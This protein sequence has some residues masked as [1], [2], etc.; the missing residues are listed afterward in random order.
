MKGLSVQKFWNVRPKL[1]FRFKAEFMTGLGNDGILGISVTRINLPKIEGQS[2]EGSIYFGN[3]NFVIPVWNI[4]SRKLEITFEETDNLDISKF[5]DKLNGI[6]WSSIPY[7]MTIVIHE[8]EEHMRDDN[9]QS[10]G[11]VCHLSSYDELSFKRDGQAGQLTIIATFIIDTII[12]NWDANSKAIYGQ[13]VVAA[14]D[15]YNPNL[16]SYKILSKNQEFKYGDLNLPSSSTKTPKKDKK[17]YSGDKYKDLN[18]DKL[19]T[20]AAFEKIKDKYPDCAITREQLEKVQKENARRMSEAYNK[21]EKKL[22]EKGIK[23]TVNAYNDA[24]HAIKLDSDKASHLLGQKID[25]QFLNQ[26]DEK[27]TITNFSDE[28]LN[29]ILD[30]AHDAGLVANWEKGSGYGWGD[31]ALADAQSIK[32]NNEIVEIHPESW[33]GEKQVFNTND[34]TISKLGKK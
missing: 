4:A 23:V 30:A 32:S 6:S 10:K 25:I 17:Y 16:D 21:F 2:G 5:I 33:T 1:P 11:Y 3:T 14:N 19:E 34:K 31:F 27:Q 13:K 24:N 15:K 20:D 8:Y 7:R 26:N 29:M 28:Q 12:N 22:A 18:V 9:V